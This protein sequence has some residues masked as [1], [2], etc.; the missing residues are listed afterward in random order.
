[1]PQ[2]VEYVNRE[3]I[4]PT[5]RGTEAR[6]Q[7]GRRIGA[8]FDQVAE[9]LRDFGNR[10]AQQIGGAVRDAGDAAAQYAAHRE[11]SQ[12]VA[13]Y[14]QLQDSLVNQWSD[15]AKNADPNDPSV[16]QKFIEGTLTPALQK[17]SDAFNT[18]AGQKW[19]QQRNSALLDHMYEKTAADMGTL[20]AQ[21]ITNNVRTVGNTFQNTAYKDPSMVE[22]LLSE[23][24][25]SIGALV[26]SS[27]NLKGAAA[28]RAKTDISEKQKEA[29]VKA[30]AQG[31]ISKS[32]DPEKT[33]EEWSRRYPQ[34]IT[35]QETQ[36]LANFAREQIRARN[37][38][39][40][41]NRRRQKE[42]TQDQSNEAAEQYIID[43][44]SR[45]PK[46]ANDPTAKDILNDPK[47]TKQDRNNLLNLIDRQLKPETDA[48]LS[49]QT[50]VGLMRDLGEPNSEARKLEQR[51]WDAYTKKE[52]GQ[53]GSMSYAD[54]ERFRKEI[55]GRK[56][57]QG[58]ALQQDRNEFFKRYAQ[59]IDAG[60]QL[61]EHTAAGSQAMYLAQ[62]DAMRQERVLSSKGI[63][64]HELYDPRSQYFFGSAKNLEKYRQGGSLQDIAK[65]RANAVKG[66]SQTYVKPPPFQPLATT[67]DKGVAS[68]EER[69]GAATGVNPT[70]VRQ[71][72]HVY[73]R[74]PD[75]S[76]KVVE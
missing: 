71:G 11:I 47:L 37:A 36:Q 25:S 28:G 14:A 68:F 12:G 22:H 23:T 49:Q 76:F 7:Q 51:A 57:P 40:E 74:Q 65:E 61:G 69:F 15:T 24:D 19:A 17:W 55:E 29:I 42:I 5:D 53:P 48:R 2:I 62:M 50:F 44:R 52:P 31:A 1:M 63:D 8:S 45:D 26:D 13:T 35:G 4:T 56:T 20:A 27:P 18:E 3:G 75:G 38:D 67:P 43:I 21:A 16:R 59:T 9:S 6:V 34:Y 32:S 64:P 10:A 66:G 39:F 33:A 30:G 46:L 54:L 58:L 72:G 73:V 70:R 41:T 60:M